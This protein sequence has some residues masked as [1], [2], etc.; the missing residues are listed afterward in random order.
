MHIILVDLYFQALSHN[1]EYCQNKVTTKYK[2]FTVIEQHH[3]NAT[4]RQTRAREIVGFAG[5]GP[6]SE[7]ENQLISRHEAEKSVHKTQFPT[8]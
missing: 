5:S 8:D 6:I 7:T 3:K 1:H 2:S 4:Y